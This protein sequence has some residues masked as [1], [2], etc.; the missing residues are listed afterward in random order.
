MPH[1]VCMRFYMCD[2]KTLS[3]IPDF[4]PP[5]QIPNGPTIIVPPDDYDDDDHEKSTAKPQDDDDDNDDDPDYNDPQLFD[6]CPVPE[7]IPD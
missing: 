6:P 5:P 1:F 4:K 3:N 7:Y 2:P